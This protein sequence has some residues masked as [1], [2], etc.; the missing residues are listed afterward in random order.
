MGGYWDLLEIHLCLSLIPVEWESPVGPAGLG[1][2]CF[3][4]HTGIFH[5]AELQEF[6]LQHLGD[7]PQGNG[8]GWLGSVLPSVKAGALERE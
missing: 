7:L 6:L 2:L 1:C 4:V 3:G 5:P 8:K